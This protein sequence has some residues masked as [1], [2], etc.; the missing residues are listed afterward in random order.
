MENAKEDNKAVSVLCHRHSFMMTI[1]LNRPHALNSL[2]LCMIRK[3]RACMDEAMAHNRYRFVLI[4][5]RGEKAFCAGGDIKAIANAVK[6]NDLKKA[7]DFFAEEYALDFLIHRFPKPVIVMAHGITMGGGLGLA[8]G[9]DFVIATR[10]T[11]MAMP[12]TRIGFFPDVGATGWMFKKC[13]EGYPEFLALTSYHMVGSECVRL[14]FASHLAQDGKFPTL[15]ERFECATEPEILP[16]DGL[17]PFLR[18]VVKSC[19]VDCIAPKPEMDHWVKTCFAGKATIQ[20]ITESL[21]TCY[22]EQSYCEDFFA[23]MKE[24]SPTAL[25]LTLTLLRQNEGQPLE[26]IFRNDLRSVEFIIRHPDFLE[27]V[28]ARIFDKDD[29]PQWNPP[30]IEEVVLDGF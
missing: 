3:I 16:Q 12:E 5:G 2:D 27:G 24:R 19:A 14:G 28:R 8:A 23:L 22:Y 29:N 13:P 25:M 1:E 10:H 15:R 20:Q 18:D 11:A 7:K 6:S 21:A 4:C 17:L 9:A 26:D 30:T